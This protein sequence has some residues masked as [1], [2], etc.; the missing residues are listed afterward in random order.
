MND[1]A[2]WQPASRPATA[3]LRANMLDRARKFFQ[4]NQVL[5]VDTPAL[6]RSAVS[7]PHIESIAASLALA[8]KA[9][10]YLHTSPEYC[11]KRLLCD[12]YPDIYQVC[13]VFRDNEA[14][15]HHQPEFTMIEWYRLDYDLDQ[16]SKETVALIAAVLDDPSLPGSVV[17][18]TYSDAFQ[19]FAGCDP[20]S[21]GVEELMALVNA[22]TSLQA[23]I[24]DDKAAWLD[25][26]FEQKVVPN[27]EAHS[28][29]V[30]THYPLD[31]AAL[32]RQCPDNP[33]VA[34]RF[35]VFIG[36]HELANGYVEL[37]DADELAKRFALNQASRRSHGQIERPLDN[38]F[39]DAV[40]HG[41]PACAGV[42]VGFDRLLMIH[43]GEDDIR[44]VQTF[45]YP[46]ME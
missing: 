36:R 22:D 43:A 5:E 3:R 19:E 37:N 7:D 34:D 21:V 30:L 16:I 11:M 42:A 29:T 38:E 44:N 8:P 32:A 26:V 46:E 9:A 23:S 18:I 33:D 45:A 27:F 6:S 12:G 40:R 17:T 25:L 41:L 24:G 1:Q 2:S 35:E 15:R 31:Q 13:K 20:L 4:S 39:L 14:G 28:L 10:H